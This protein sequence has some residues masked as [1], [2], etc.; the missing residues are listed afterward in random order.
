MV[1]NGKLIASSSNSGTVHVWDAST[2]ANVLTYR[3]HTGAVYTVAWSPNGMRI[4]VEDK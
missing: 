1:T 2:G 4:A 3:G